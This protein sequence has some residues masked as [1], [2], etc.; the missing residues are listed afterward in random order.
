MPAVVE[1]YM[2]RPSPTAGRIKEVVVWVLAA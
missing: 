1:K 2:D